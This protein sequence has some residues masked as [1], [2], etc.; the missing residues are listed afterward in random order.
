MTVACVLVLGIGAPGLQAQERPAVPVVPAGT[1][2]VLL[3]VQSVQPTPGGAWPGG[4]TSRQE[5]LERLEAELAFAFQELGAVE[6]AM[7]AAVAERSRRNP[8]A[9]VNPR[10]LAYQ[11]LLS[12]P[13]PRAQLYEP[14]HGQLRVVAAM[15]DARLVVLP[16]ALRYEVAVPVPEDGAPPPEADGASPDVDGE[17]PLDP[18][19]KDDGVDSSDFGRASLL[20]AV[21]D[22]RRSAVLWHGTIEG[23]PGEAIS[24]RILT[25]LALRVA[26]ELTP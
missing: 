10:R 25:S 15:F 11:G 3:P 21:V 7:P 4:A 19:V 12:K 17:P 24:S 18:S 13:D 8:L 5:T 16:L 14:L 9:Q 26:A 2:V 1:P 23:D 6:W 20:L 22:I